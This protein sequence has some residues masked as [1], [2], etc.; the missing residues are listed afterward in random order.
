MLL[1]ISRILITNFPW[2]V[3]GTSFTSHMMEQDNKLQVL[4]NLEMMIELRELPSQDSLIPHFPNMSF[5]EWVKTLL[6]M[7][8]MV[9]LLDW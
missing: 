8:S 3:F 7:D 2:K 1:I 9:Q 4:L 5:S 6:M